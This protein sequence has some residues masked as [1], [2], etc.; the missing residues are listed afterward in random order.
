MLASAV[1][2]FRESLEA[3]LI[4]SIVLSATRG[5]LHR[6][7]WVSIG[8]AAGILGSLLVAYFARE[9]ST[10][11]MG[12]GQELFNASILLSA[13]AMLGWHNVWMARH[14]REIA[15]NMNRVGRLVLDGERHMST[16]AIV[17]GL[18]VL[19]EGSEVVLFTAGLLSGGASASQALAGGLLG[20]LAGA[21]A[22]LFLY[23]GLVRVPMRYFFKVTG[24]L[25]LLLAAGLSAQAAGFLI[26]AGW[27]PALVS[28]LWD[29]SSLLS[30]ATIVGQ[31]LHTLIGYSARP[32]AMQVIFYVVTLVV[33]AWLMQAFNRSGRIEN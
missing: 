21:S 30:E 12:A 27:L 3:A 15:A 4:I 6:G 20:L 23:L 10:F 5:L 31:L 8:V 16:L 11:A 33:I 25:I 18:A 22:G 19:R 2:L 29:S 24:W 1:I 9:I 7:R 26:Q 17:V 14:G 28:P 13:T 32:A